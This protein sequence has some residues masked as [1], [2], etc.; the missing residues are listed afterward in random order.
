MRA[1]FLVL[2]LASPAMAGQVDFPY[3]GLAIDVD[4]GVSIPTADSQYLKFADATAKIGITGG[5]EFALHKMF[6]IA[7]EIGFDIIPVNSDDNTFNANNAHFNAS[8][9]R[10]RFLVGA[11]FALRF[12]KAEPF[13]RLKIGADYI[14]GNVTPPFGNTS[15]Y[16]S[17]A[18][19]FKPSIGFQYEVWKHL[20]IGGEFATPVAGHDFGN[21]GCGV[22]PSCF[23][24]IGPRVSFT[25]FDI[26]IAAFAGF[27]Y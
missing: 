11:R 20:V 9:T 10:F 22:F 5:W 6:L 18:F 17:A 25:A 3:H 26:E 24:A 12:D 14:G 4:V 15:D 27:R 7:P 19:V 8:F 16:S 23:N 13:V 21:V 2:L 1:A